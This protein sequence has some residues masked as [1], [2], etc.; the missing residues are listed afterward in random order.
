[1]QNK[2]SLFDVVEAWSRC[3]TDGKVE[4]CAKVHMDGE[5]HWHCT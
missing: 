2:C 5:E 1:M 3:E 4:A